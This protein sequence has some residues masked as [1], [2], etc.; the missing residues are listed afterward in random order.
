M[1]DFAPDDKYYQLSFPFYGF[2]KFNMVSYPVPS[3]NNCFFHAIMLAMIKDYRLCKN[4]NDEKIDRYKLVM[5]F[6]RNLSN[7]LDTLYYKLSRGCLEDYSKY[8]PGFTLEDMKKLIR[9]PKCV[10]LEAI[11]L[12]SIVLH[13]NILILDVNLN[14]VYMIGDYELVNNKNSGYVVILY[15]EKRVHYELCGIKNNEGNI[16]TY[17]N[18]NHTFIKQIKNRIDIRGNKNNVLA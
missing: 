4:K 14:D 3:D 8:I 5:E 16:V 18:K 15:D 10:G 2:E 11:E 17:F 1:S 13:V 7:K 9:E 6:R 12:T